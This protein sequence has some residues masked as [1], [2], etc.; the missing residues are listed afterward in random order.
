DRKPTVGQENSQEHSKRHTDGREEVQHISNLA[1]T[2]IEPFNEIKR[3][4]KGPRTTSPASSGT[5]ITYHYEYGT[6]FSGSYF[7]YSQLLAWSRHQK[8]V[9][10]DADAKY[11][12][13]REANEGRPFEPIGRQF[14][15]QHMQRSR[16]QSTE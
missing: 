9:Q 16:Q 4:N 1:A 11:R 3:A 12:D 5:V 10:R 8:Q 15:D 14:D 2:E 6:V 7:A 13:Q